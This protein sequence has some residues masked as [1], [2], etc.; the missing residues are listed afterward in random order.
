MTIAIKTMLLTLVLTALPV[1][2]YG[3]SA[4]AQLGVNCSHPTIQQTQPS[5]RPSPTTSPQQ[6]AM[7]MLQRP[8]TQ[9]MLRIGGTG[10][11]DQAHFSEAYQQF[12]N[13]FANIAQ[14]GPAELGLCRLYERSGA[15]GNAIT[16]CRIATESHRFAHGRAVKKW[17]EN[18]MIPISSLYSSTRKNIRT[19]WRFT[20]RS[21]AA[22]KQPTSSIMESSPSHRSRDCPSISAPTPRKQL[23]IAPE[24]RQTSLP[25][26]L[27]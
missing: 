27:L 19:P 1:I 11:A 26:P 15:Y 5:S 13:A 18:E 8:R 6:P 3:Q 25:V 24:Q 12:Q 4:C 21:V 9:A 16:A 17:L 2:A 10:R 23:P 22:V 14:Y 20:T 7:T